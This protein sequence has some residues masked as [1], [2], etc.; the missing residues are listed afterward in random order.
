M[1]LRRTLSLW[2]VSV[3]GVGIILGAGVY[4]LIGPAAAL[5]GPGLWLSFVIAG[6]AAALTAYSYA[7]LGAMRPK[8]S[9]EFQYTALAFGPNAGFVAGWLMLGGDIAAAAS[10]ALGF[11]GYLGHLTG[12]PVAVGAAALVLTAGMAMYAGIGH[13]IAIAAVLTVIEAAGL[14]LVI[15]VGIPSWPQ[16]DFSV[17]ADATA[18]IFGAAA[19]IFFAYLGF[20]ELGNLAEEMRAPERDLPRALFVA[21]GAT[22]LIYVAVALSA[23]AVVPAVALGESAAPLALVVRRVLGRGADLALTLMALAATANTVLLLLL[24]AARSVYG[25]AEAGVLPRRL[26]RL[27]RTEVP[28]ESMI[29]ILVLTIALVAAGNLA[30]VARLTDA[31]VLLSFAGV[32]TALTWLG[33]QR[34][35]PGGAWQRARAIAISS[36]GALMCG[37]LLWHGGWVWIVAAGGV[38]VLGIAWLVAGRAVAGNA[39]VR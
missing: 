28:R 2:Q 23:T 39:A 24:A 11:G 15:A 9:P 33:V 5:A 19:L 4:A 6:L 13:A 30:R 7:R 1:T 26:A 3:T 12:T 21:L 27:T 35:L 16:L 32:N 34:L 14:A 36:A 10:V 25:M 38:G 17:T 20:D 37:W 18:G 29:V 31:M 8:A 22:T